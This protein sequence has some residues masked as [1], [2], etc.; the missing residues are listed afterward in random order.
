M[1]FLE[2]WE[3]SEKKFHKPYYSPT[4]TW[5]TP[6][7]S[8]LQVNCQGLWPTRPSSEAPGPFPFTCSRTSLQPLFLLQH[9]HTFPPP[10]IF[11]Q[12]RNMVFLSPL[13][14]K[15]IP[16]SHIYP[17]ATATFS[18]FLLTK[19]FERVEYTYILLFLSSH[20]LM[21]PL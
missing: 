17:S 20:S 4:C 16:S 3:Q 12:H 1:Y 7:H 19:S 10:W 6:R 8:S 13:L 18:S 21:N 15:K 9:N 2:K 14:K 5:D 11:H